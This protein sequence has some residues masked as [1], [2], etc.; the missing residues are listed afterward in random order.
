MGVGKSP[1][2]NIPEEEKGKNVRRLKIIQNYESKGQEEV[3]CQECG[4]FI[5]TK[6]LK[7]CKS[8]KKAHCE[9]DYYNR[10][11]ELLKFKKR[12]KKAPDPSQENEEE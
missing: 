10:N 4:I 6:V 3:E 11:C 8:F 12:K 5:P 9:E 7:E 1:I 2:N